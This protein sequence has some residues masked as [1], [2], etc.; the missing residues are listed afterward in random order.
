MRIMRC[1]RHTDA[2]GRLYITRA[3]PILGLRVTPDICVDTDA[4]NIYPR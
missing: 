4:L 2:V 1:P 3:M